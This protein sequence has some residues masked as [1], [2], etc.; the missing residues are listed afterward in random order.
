MDLIKIISWLPVIQLFK[1][2]QKPIS[3]ISPLCQVIHWTSNGAMFAKQVLNLGR[4][5]LLE[6]FPKV[7]GSTLL[8]YS[9]SVKMTILVLKNSLIVDAFQAECDDILINALSK[10]STKHRQVIFQT[11]PVSCAIIQVLSLFIM[12]KSPL[13][14]NF[15][16]VHAYEQIFGFYWAHSQKM[17]RH[18]H[19]FQEGGGHVS[20]HHHHPYIPSCSLLSRIQES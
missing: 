14:W 11:Q 17:A 12:S 7:P 13:K 16:L 5:S 19:H 6:P 15:L 18:R 9:L 3:R 2:A 4:F 20:H 10:S 8:G 1:I